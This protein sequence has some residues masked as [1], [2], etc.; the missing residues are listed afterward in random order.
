MKFIRKC[1]VV[2]LVVVAFVLV[3][4]TAGENA[5]SVSFSDITTSGNTNITFSV[6]Y[7]DEK[8]YQNKGTDILIKADK[9]NVSFKIKKELENFVEI[10]LP[11]KNTYY[12]LS[13]LM[14]GSGFEYVLYKDAVSKNYI[15]NSDIDFVLTLKAI[16][17]ELSEH[18][19]M[20]MNPFD[21]SREYK[22]TVKKHEKQ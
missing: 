13:K 8:M 10:S 5:I 18:K 12:S 15:I 7:E 17:G 22:L 9:D 14:Q 19:T 6:K 21:A 2:V 3:A 1:L 20:L 16:V 11:Q 4:C